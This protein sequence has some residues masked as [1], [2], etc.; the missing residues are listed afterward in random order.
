MENKLLLAL[1][2]T[3]NNTWFK[4][5][6][7]CAHCPFGYGYCSSQRKDEDGTVIDDTW[8]CD[9]L[10][11]FDDVY[12]Y[13]QSN[14][15]HQLSKDE[16]KER[17]LAAAPLW[18]ENLGCGRLQNGWKLVQT[19]PS[20]KNEIY[21]CDFEKKIFLSLRQ[22]GKTWRAWAQPRDIKETE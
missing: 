8:T 13:I 7:L 9:D 15:Q 2:C 3:L 18:F 10:K 1:K 4:Q 12:K 22:Y 20:L 5:R 16:V 6:A 21:I 11:I 19:I 17:A 14:G